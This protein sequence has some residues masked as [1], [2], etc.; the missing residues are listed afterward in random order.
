MFVFVLRLLLFPYRKSRMRASSSARRTNQADCT[1]WMFFLPSN[2]MK[3]IS[4]NTEIFS[5]NTLGLSSA[6]KS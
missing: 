1:D 5:G 3:E 6:W 2:V 4:P